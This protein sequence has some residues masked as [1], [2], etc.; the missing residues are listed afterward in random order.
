MH[1]PNLLY[2]GNHWFP[3]EVTYTFEL[4]Q[5]SK[6]QAGAYFG[7]AQSFEKL[8]QKILDDH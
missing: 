7:Q 1:R 4:K 8:V 6:K 3:K 5:I 2:L